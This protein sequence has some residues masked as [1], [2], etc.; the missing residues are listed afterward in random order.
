MSLRWRGIDPARDRRNPIVTRRK[1]LPSDFINADGV[2]ISEAHGYLA[3]LIVVVTVTIG[4]RSR[5][6]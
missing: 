3:P 1:P 2:A 5:F 6:Q 4:L